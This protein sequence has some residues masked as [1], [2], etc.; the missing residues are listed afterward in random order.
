MENDFR[1][2]FKEKVEPTHDI[3]VAMFGFGVWKGNAK[4]MRDFLDLK[5]PVARLKSEWDNDT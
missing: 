3:D 4:T 5:Q 2:V 1:T